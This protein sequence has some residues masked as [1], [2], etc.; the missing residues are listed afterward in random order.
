MQHR[1]QAVYAGQPLNRHSTNM[2]ISVEHIDTA[3][4][5]HNRT[6]QMSRLA[7]VKHMAIAG[8]GYAPKLQK[9]LRSIGMFFHYSYYIQRQAF[10]NDRFSEPPV[11]LSD[12]TEKGQFS[13]L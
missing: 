6:F 11:P 13:N 7:F 5:T 9:L 1:K 10:N 2:N 8:Q 12:P 4:T 3:G